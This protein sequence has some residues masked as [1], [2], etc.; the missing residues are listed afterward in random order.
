MDK[1]QTTG[2]VISNKMN[3]TITVAVKHKIQHKKYK[4]IVTKTNKYYA[5]DES[6][7]CNIGDIVKIQSHRP[8]SKK[9]RW[10]LIEKILEK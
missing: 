9:K 4:K 7:I 3:K 1:K 5:H 6:N 8:L 10:I 2:T